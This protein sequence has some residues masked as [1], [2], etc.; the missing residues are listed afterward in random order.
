MNQ[1]PKVYLARAGRSGEDE[2]RALDH[3]IAIIGFQ[4][5]PSLAGAS[6]YEDV[7]KIVSQAFPD[8]KPRAVGN[9]AGQLWAFAVAMK[10]GDHVVLPRKL[11]SQ[12][13]IGRVAG[14]Y[15]Y[16]QIGRHFPSLAFS[17]VASDG[18][19]SNCLGAGPPLFVRCLHDCV[20]H[21]TQ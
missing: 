4:E 10:E 13:A 8:A 1:A 18:S 5:V 7:H 21:L 9:F 3:N 16:R 12:I 14:P 17:R 19:T 20:Q 15:E 11:T 2:V 6:N